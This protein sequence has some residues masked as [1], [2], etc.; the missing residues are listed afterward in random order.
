MARK[1]LSLSVI[2]IVLPIA[3]LLATGAVLAFIFAT[4][5]GQFDD[6]ETPKW[7]MLW[8]DQPL[9]PKKESAESTSEK[10]GS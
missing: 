6:L 2:Y 3:L 9:A 1:E 8:D 7:R 10:L 4:K 5:R